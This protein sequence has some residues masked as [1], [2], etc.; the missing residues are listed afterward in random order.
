MLKRVRLGADCWVKGVRYSM[1]DIVELQDGDAN[2]LIVMRRAELAPEPPPA[3][4][5]PAKA[6]APPLP[7]PP[8]PAAPRKQAPKE[9]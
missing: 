9:G 3:P 4:P 8:R 1:G 5:A 6:A 2:D 7:S